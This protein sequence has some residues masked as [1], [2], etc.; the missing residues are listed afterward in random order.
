M[1]WKTHRRTGRS[2]LRRV[3]GFELLR[4][5]VSE[6]GVQPLPIV[7]L[8]DELFQM[9]VQ[10]VDVLV[11]DGVDLLALEGLDEA[12]AEGVVVG[13]GG[14]LM[15]GRMPWLPSMRVYCSEQYWMPRSEWCTRPAAG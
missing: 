14:R 9:G 11:L 10:F 12:L 3:G 1:P 13:V 8:L 6:G 5:P 15:L 2:G 4:G 7:V